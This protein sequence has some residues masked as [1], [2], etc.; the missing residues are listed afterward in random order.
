MW[1]GEDPAEYREGLGQFDEGCHHPTRWMEVLVATGRWVE[2]SDYR[3]LYFTVSGGVE[4]RPEEGAV[5]FVLDEFRAT[6]RLA[7][8]VGS[9][10]EGQGASARLLDD[11][12]VVV[13]QSSSTPYGGH[14]GM[15][16]EHDQDSETYASL[17]AW[18][19]EWGI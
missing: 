11:G 7:A 9:A 18:L 4:V 8:S 17:E 14:D 19:A 10:Y 16:A 13:C 6:R 1:E 2:M 12:R 3:L 15:T 5:S